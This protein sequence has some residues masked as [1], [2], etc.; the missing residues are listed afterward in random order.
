MPETVKPPGVGAPIRRVVGLPL[1]AALGGLESL[2]LFGLLEEEQLECHP[3]DLPIRVH[4]FADDET[5][6]ARV[7]QGHN[8]REV[9]VDVLAGDVNPTA[10]AFELDDGADLS[11]RNET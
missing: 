7:V 6:N 1:A 11:G 10:G 8:R 9:D 3:A 2:R 4:G 5:T